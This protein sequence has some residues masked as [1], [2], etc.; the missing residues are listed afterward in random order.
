MIEFLKGRK[1][2]W[3]NLG[4]KFKYVWDFTQDEMDELEKRLEGIGIVVGNLDFALSNPIDIV[5]MSV[6]D[7]A[8]CKEIVAVLNYRKEIGK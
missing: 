6:E 3:E 1:E 7:F 4:F 5:E 8:D 2:E